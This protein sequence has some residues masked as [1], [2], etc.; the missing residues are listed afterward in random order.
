VIASTTFV[1]SRAGGPRT[2]RRYP[3]EQLRIRRCAAFAP[4][5]QDCISDLAEDAFSSLNKIIADKQGDL[6]PIFQKLA[7]FNECA[8]GVHAQ[9]LALGRAEY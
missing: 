9:I 4:Q 8:R 7:E 1:V 3:G 2:G 5:G 6:N